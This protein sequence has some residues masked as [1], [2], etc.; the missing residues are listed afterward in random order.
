M[1]NPTQVQ[2][3]EQTALTTAEQLLPVLLAAIA[4]GAQAA[5]PQAAVIA[6]V[7]QVIPPLLQ[8]F[9][10]NSSQIEQLMT[11]LVTQINANQSAFDATAQ[12]RGLDVPA[13]A[14]P[15]AA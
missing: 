11:A 10:A 9:S 4:S 15:Q 7:A 12:T 3:I 2:T 13:L 6:M 8:S 5:T 14:S 1:T